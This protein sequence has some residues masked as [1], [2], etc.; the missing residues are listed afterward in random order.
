M[1]QRLQ[2]YGPDRLEEADK[3]MDSVIKIKADSDTATQAKAI[4]ER[5]V[6]MKDQIDKSKKAEGSAPAEKEDK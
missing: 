2:V 4:K 3:L 5:I 6:E 1:M